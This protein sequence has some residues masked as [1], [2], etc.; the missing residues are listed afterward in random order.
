[1]T[2]KEAP[3]EAESASEPQV[4]APT[5][6]PER[7]RELLNELFAP[8]AP[9]AEA[10]SP[11]GDAASASTTVAVTEFTSSETTS[12]SARPD[13]RVPSPDSPSV[14]VSGSP[15]STIHATAASPEPS[16]NETTRDPFDLRNYED[17]FEEEPSTTSSELEHEAPPA[18]ERSRTLRTRSPQPRRNAAR[19]IALASLGI[20]TCLG[21]FAAVS[22]ILHRHTHRPPER[23]SMYSSSIDSADPLAASKPSASRSDGAP[24]KA[25][26]A[27]A[28]ADTVEMLPAIAEP[29]L[30]STSASTSSS[31]VAAG[32]P[33]STEEPTARSSRADAELAAADHGRATT[34]AISRTAVAKRQT[35]KSPRPA[36][37]T[38]RALA[39]RTSTGNRSTSEPEK[40]APPP[41]PTSV[42][43]TPLLPPAE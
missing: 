3:P 35:T 41:S 40:S 4:P 8:D 26:A 21:L 36:V 23:T 27:D 18:T 43:D 7:E 10:A 32:Q 15:A 6:E 19:E 38:K 1:M 31:A 30:A 24:S 12:S 5:V 16:P 28:R 37:R 9:P 2:S 13:A 34:A 25:S 33:A 39:G 42:L 14:I 17:W 22:P 20:V 29:G 11:G